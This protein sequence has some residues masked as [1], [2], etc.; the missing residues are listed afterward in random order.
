MTFLEKLLPGRG[1]YCVAKALPSGAMQHYLL[2][3]VASVQATVNALDN[4]GH[5]CF[6]A[7]G[8]L[9]VEAKENQEHNRRLP[10]GHDRNLRK[11]VRTQANV[12]ELKNFFLD[13]DCGEKWALKNQREGIA[14]L[15]Q[16][17]ASTGLP[18][19]AVVNS[20]NGL[21][22]HWILSESVPARKWRAIADVLKRVVEAYSPELGDD[23]SRTSDTASVLRPIGSTNRKPGRPQ[24]EVTLLR[25]AE[26]V[27]LEEFV[28]TLE[29]AAKKKHVRREVL[30]APKPQSDLNAEFF[31]G[32]EGP[33]KD[34]DLVADNCQQVAAMR[35]S[36]ESISH[37]LWFLCVGVLSHCEGGD[38]CVREWTRKESRVGRR[39]EDVIAQWQSSEMGPSTCATIGDEN[40]QG[41]I[42]CPHNGKI[43]SPIVLGLPAPEEKEVDDGQCSPP[44]RFRRGEDGLY[45]EVDGRWEKFYDQDL[46]VERLAFDESLGYEV[47]TLKHTLPHEGAMECTLRSSLVTDPK[48]L[49]TAL[50]DN[51]VKVVGMKEKQ[52]MTYYLEGYQAKLQR[53]RRMS[54]L[55]CQMGWKESREADPMFVLGKKILHAD[56]TVEEAG[57]ARNV[58]KS[59]EAYHTKGDPGKWVNATS[60]LG[61]SG[62][63]PHAFAFL[64]GAFG[65]PLFKFTGFDGAILSM[66]G[67]SGAGKTLMLRFLQSAWGFHKELLIYGGDTPKF[68]IQ[69]VGVY[70][71]LPVAVDEVTNMPNQELSSF[72]YQMTQGRDRGRLTRNAEEKKLLNSWNTLAVTSSNAS[73][74]ERLAGMKQ[75]A[76]AEIN[77]IFEYPVNRHPRFQEEVTRKLYWTLHENYG[78]AG[79]AYVQWLLQNASRVQGQIGKVRD[80]LDSQAGVTGEERF[81]GAVAASAIYGGAVASKLGL[82]K[83]D[84]RPV[85]E[86]AVR[87]LGTMRTAKHES[88]GTPVETLAQFIDQHISNML[89]VKG[90]R[91]YVVI[92]EPRGALHMRYEPDSRALY[93]ARPV[94]NTW[95][96]KTYGSYSQMKTDLMEQ[97]VLVDPNRRK[98]LG[99]GTQF[100]G[101][102]QPCWLVNLGAPALQGQVDPI[103]ETAAVLEAPQK[104]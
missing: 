5:T 41:C 90:P 50:F 67:N 12:Q 20:G 62:M 14:A 69:R 93:I 59:V 53:K 92:Q 84:V 32:L 85:T 17:V 22:A 63:E 55:L 94:L 75:D 18:F 47:M 101:A 79:I 43:K 74:S 102:Q 49:I 73:L 19:P 54:M 78:H 100:G 87:Q 1:V 23:S 61:L 3:D 104:V 30:L 46:W 37:N 10:R 99:A 57:L 88:I 70:G 34:P 103:M 40:P 89:I 68:V 29:A 58:P 60:L 44:D 64:A 95:L 27:N 52:A 71:N 80:S 65:A 86:W 72:A 21:Y 31:V 33:K 39:T 91:P 8:T 98:T 24:R 9:S 77:R 83:F 35:D 2:D 76:T 7:Q 48:Q 25:D 96:T 66:V 11:G 97:R 51:H 26:E 38:E 4:A 42:G 13:I 6:V 36:E 28:E 56:L 16:F 82:I 45:M 15:K 81:W